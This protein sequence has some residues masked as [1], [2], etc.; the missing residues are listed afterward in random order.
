MGIDLDAARAARREAKGKTPDPVTFM[1]ETFVLPVELPIAAVRWFSKLGEASKAK[2]GIAITEALEAA[3]EA[4]FS[5]TDFERFMALQPSLE[6]LSAIIEGVPGEYGMTAG[7][8][9]ASDT[10]SKSTGTR[11]RR[12]SKPATEST[13]EK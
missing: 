4:I 8:P 7:E 6:D 10:S 1:G 13:P 5:A 3:V 9:Q 12:A 2:D 11:S